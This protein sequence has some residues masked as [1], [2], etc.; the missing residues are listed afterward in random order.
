MKDVKI[1]DMVLLHEDDLHFNL[2]VAK[3]SDLATMGS[4]SYRHN[5]GPLME[6]IDDENTEE[7]D[8]VEDNQ[9]N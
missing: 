7:Q 8:L 4:L 6:K 5:I 2:I 3:D 9:E 1:D